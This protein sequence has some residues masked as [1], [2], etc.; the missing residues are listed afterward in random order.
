MEKRPFPAYRGDEPYVF[1]SYAHADSAEVYPLLIALRDMGIRIWYDEGIEPGSKW[2]EELSSAIQNAEQVLFVASKRSVASVNCE[3]EIDYALSLNVP[4][5][6]AYIENVELPPALSFS[7]GSHQGVFSAHYDAKTFQEKVFNSLT[8]APEKRLGQIR[9][10]MKKRSG[11]LTALA[12]LVL[13][14]LLAFLVIQATISDDNAAKPPIDITPTIEAP[15][16]VAVKPLR[17]ATDDDELNWVGDGLANLIRDQL[18][19]SRY[20][21]VLSP[22]SWLNLAENAQSE[23]ELIAGARRNGIDY[24]V[25]GEYLGDEDNLLAT[26]R[27]TNLRAGIDVMS[28]TYP[29]LTTTQLVNSSTRISLN[30]KQAMKIPRT[31]EL[32][33][34][35]ADFVTENI[36]AYEAYVTGLEFYNRFAYEE[37]ESSMRTALSISP[38]FFIARYRLADILSATGRYSEAEKELAAIPDAA[39]EDAREALYIEGFRHVL[40]GDHKRAIET[41]QAILEKFPYEIEAQQL[42]ARAYYD[43]LQKEEA[44]D[45]LKKL[46]LQEPEN[47]HVLGALGF[48]LMN[49]GELKKAGETLD[50]YIDL[51]PDMPNARELRGALRLREAK[52]SEAVEDFQKALE[53]DP[54][55]VAAKIGLARAQAF[56]GQLSAAATGFMTIRDDANLPPRHRIDAGFDLAYLYRAQERPSDIPG[57]IEPLQ[58]LIIE[59]GVRAGLYWYVLA[60]AAADQGNRELAFDHLDRGDSSNPRCRRFRHGF[61]TKKGLLKARAGEPIDAEIEGLAKY[62][63]PDDNPDRTEDKAIDHLLGV[64]ALA[65]G[66]A[67]RAVEKLRSASDQFGYEYGIYS[68]ELADALFAAGDRRQAFKTVEKAREINDSL[69]SGEVRLDLLWHRHRA[70]H[71]QAT[72]YEKTSKPKQA[73]ALLEVIHGGN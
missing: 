68:I 28:Q 9:A 73:E 49:L 69:L 20:A 22:V 43:N 63:L 4:V 65:D 40:S 71:L 5:R 33:T 50:A 70:A 48:Q 64:K 59:E 47:P 31:N 19:A 25:S 37:A 72:F 55:F 12:A 15:V 66:D 34:L 11:A 17:N 35:A 46:R 29:N 32:Q 18:S 8:T 41:Y 67:K 56:D 3:R 42:L 26:M 53:L 27:V 1:V 13:S 10:T 21:V 60:Q 58:Q 7:L 61:F 45:V 14:P 38:T 44:I 24:I 30:I 39:A 2:R 52:I 23:A 57:A 54:S 51:Y 62:R 6:V 36:A 16:R